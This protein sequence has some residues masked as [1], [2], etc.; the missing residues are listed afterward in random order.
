MDFKN[1]LTYINRLQA[2]NDRTWFQ[3]HKQEFLDQQQNA[4]IHTPDDKIPAGA[5]PEAGE[6]PDHHDI[7]D[8]LQG[9]DPVAA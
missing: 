2:N 7:A 6:Q 8:V 3:E 1:I 5:V 9:A 4:I